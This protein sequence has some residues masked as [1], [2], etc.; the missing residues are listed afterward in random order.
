MGGGDDV[1]EDVEA[2]DLGVRRAVGTEDRTGIELRV[3]GDERAADVDVRQVVGAVAGGGLPG[4]LTAGDATVEGLGR[5]EERVDAGPLAHGVDDL[6]DALVD[7]RD[8]TD[9]DADQRACAGG[10]GG[11]C[12][13]SDVFDTEPSPSF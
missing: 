10:G 8:G 9:L 4:D 5:D 12:V 7:E 6:G 1:A 3:L 11:P 2:L 13:V